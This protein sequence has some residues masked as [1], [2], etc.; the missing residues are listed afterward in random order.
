M[1]VSSPI[2][3]RTVL[4]TN[5]VDS[6]VLAYLRTQCRVVENAESRPW[7]RQ[8]L[9]D[10]ARDATAILAFMTDCIDE[11]FLA[12]C[13]KLRIVACALKGYDNF[14]VE[15]FTR[16]GVWLTVVPHLLTVPTAELALGLMI[17][18]A[19]N[20]ADGD[21]FVRSGTF[22]GWRPTYSGVLIAGAT[23]GIV[24]MGA[25]GQALAERLAGFGVR[26]VYCDPRPLDAAAE[27][28]LRVARLPFDELLSASD[29]VILAAPLSRDTVHLVDAVALARIKRGAILVNVARGSLVDEEAVAAALDDGTLAAYAADVFEMEDWARPDRPRSI[30][31]RLMGSP[32]TVL[33]P[34]LGS[35]IPSVRR[36]IAMQAADSIVQFLRGV[37]PPPGA[38]NRPS[39]A[40]D[41]ASC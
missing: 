38:V 15:A 14:D 35:A 41:L 9:L 5:P 34:H 33:T 4:I 20:I 28:E 8:E 16:R 24:G 17:A 30:S 11:A 29:I 6:E 10:H 36:E 7:T 19:R 18:A 22:Q 31:P 3:S 12:A 32:K 26:L 13:P 37:R 39:Y 25:L 40:F 21:R 2:D 1:N 27:R 23:V